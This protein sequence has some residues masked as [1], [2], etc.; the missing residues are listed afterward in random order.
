MCIRD[1]AGIV[2]DDGQLYWR[3]FCY[4]K[5]EGISLIRVLHATSEEPG[6]VTMTEW[7]NR[8]GW[9]VKADYAPF[10]TQMRWIEA[11]R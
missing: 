9:G 10:H 6:M 2:V 1:R 7:L 11:G 8:Q 3:D 5:D 4:A